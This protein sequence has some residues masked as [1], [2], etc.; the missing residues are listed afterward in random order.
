MSLT[1]AQ[2]LAFY[3]NCK[4]WPAIGLPFRPSELHIP[5]VISQLD[6]ELIE[7]A[8]QS[9]ASGV[10]TI[11]LNLD[12][13]REIAP[14]LLHESLFH[15]YKAF[16]N[17]LA[18]RT[19]YFGGMLHWINVTLYYASFYLARSVTVLFGRQ[20]YQVT[21]KV[22]GYDEQPNPIFIRQVAEALANTK[23]KQPDSYRLCINIDIERQ[24]GQIIFDKTKVL[25]HEDVW[26]AYEAIL[27]EIQ[28][29]SGLRLFPFNGSYLK[30][31]R[32]KENYSFE[33]YDH[34]DFNLYPA[35]FEGYFERD[36]YIKRKANTIF[37]DLS[38]D[39][40]VALSLQLNLYRKLQVDK[41]P[42]ESEKFSYMID[43][44]LPES[45]A[46]E[47]LL[48]LCN[49]NFPTQYLSSEDGSIF[50]DE[51]GRFL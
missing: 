29:D 21:R 40:F 32:N 25:S 19:L 36:D 51:Q 17:Y 11:N 8:C 23:G 44:C 30:Q 7:E 46:K 15:F 33:G 26:N 37:D 14:V 43:Y 13:C 48:Q 27:R 18:A 16:Y 24:E 47:N 31:S 45:K 41:L 49:E 3:N 50:C 10:V 42:I 2:I 22:R 12:D 5:K 28:E 38:K 9:V 34:L 39:I 35:G 6:N 4:Y 20:S 1:E